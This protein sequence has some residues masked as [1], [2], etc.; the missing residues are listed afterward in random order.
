MI[1]HSDHHEAVL[2]VAKRSIVLLKNEGNLLPLDKEKKGVLIGPL[3]ADKNSPLGN[4][5]ANGEENSAISLL[6]GMQAYNADIKYE[7]GVKLLNEK[8]L[9]PMELI[10]NETDRTGIDE[11]VEAAKNADVVIMA[12]G[13]HGFQSGEGRSRATL[14]LPGLQQELLEK[15][16]EVNKKIVLVN[17]SGRTLV[18]TWAAEHIPTIIQAW[19]LGSQSGHAIAQVLY[20]DY[21]PSGKLPMTFPRSLGQVP[22]YYNHK[23]TGC[24]TEPA[25]GLVYWSHYSDESN[26]PLYAFGHGLS[27]T[28]FEYSQ[29]QIEQ[30]DPQEF[31]V[32]VTIKNIGM[33]DGEEVVQLYL[34]D[35]V[36]S[37]TRPIKELKAF[38]KI[39]LKKGEEKQVS[40]TLNAEQLGFY[41]NQGEFSVEK[42][43][44]DISVGGGSVGG[45]ASSFTLD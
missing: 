20:G 22:I 31:T 15:V 3:A 12:L 26:D 13:E 32:Q 17:M 37:V 2:D 10:I 33:F 28:N 24:P 27:Y 4:W 9:F 30:K 11:A 43:E 42:G 38:E 18:L 21:N 36:A 19:Q 8:G 39:F 5:R 35:K 25:P 44:F 14:D 34:R 1:G 29:L 16:Y 40:F 23:T 7:R 45:L 41:N 6:E